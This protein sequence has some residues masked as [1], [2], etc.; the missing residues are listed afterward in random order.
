M[1]RCTRPSSAAELKPASAAT[2]STSRGTLSV[3]TS[4]PRAAVHVAEV[5]SAGN[6]H[7]EDGKEHRHVHPVVYRAAGR[8]PHRRE[9]A[10]THLV[11]VAHH[12]HHGRAVGRVVHQLNVPSAPVDHDRL[13][14][15][16]DSTTAIC[17]SGISFGVSVR[18]GTSREDS[19][20]C[21]T[22]PE[23]RPRCCSGASTDRRRRAG[24]SKHVES[25]VLHSHIVVFAVY[26]F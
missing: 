22:A 25:V 19:G 24:A 16:H 6:D 9:G 8:A 12:H 14:P 7:A 2:Y 20:P 10:E 1:P 13:V 15:D 18:T 3:S 26:K 17:A 5:H 23:G 21:C 4:L 11:L